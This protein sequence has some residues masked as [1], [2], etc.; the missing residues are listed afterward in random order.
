MNIQQIYNAIKNAA[1]V[2]I[3]QY[4][5]E[6]N[7]MLQEKW[8]SKD[9]G[10]MAAKDE[11]GFIVLNVLDNTKQVKAENS[12]QFQTNSISEAESAVIRKRIEGSLGL[13]LFENISELPKNYQWDELDISKIANALPGTK[14]YELVWTKKS[15]DGKNVGY[16]WRGF[17]EDGTNRPLRVEFYRSNGG[18]SKYEL[19]TIHEIE[20]LSEAQMGE[21]LSQVL[22]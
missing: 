14:I 13:M 7:K 5:T 10:I 9:R 19:Q 4:E 21:V 16:K 11:N 2:H 17:V 18:S 1:N 12:R 3:K 22:P 6:E 15:L 20:Y 8:I